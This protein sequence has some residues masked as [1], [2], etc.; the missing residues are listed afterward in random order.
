M[1]MTKLDKNRKQ[2]W[3]Q[4]LKGLKRGATLTWRELD[5]W[6]DGDAA[7]FSKDVK[8]LMKALDRHE[9]GVLRGASQEAE[10]DAPYVFHHGLRGD[11]AQ[12]YEQELEQLPR[13]SRVGEFRMARRYE[14][15]RARMAQAFTAIGFADE[16][17]R[18]ILLHGLEGIE[19]PSKAKRA[20]KKRE[21]ALARLSEVEDLRNAFFEGS[22]YLVM[23]GV[24]KYRK[25]GIDTLDLVQ[26]GNVS[27]FQAAEGFDWRR[28]VRF[29]TYAEYWINQAFLK[30]LYNN[31]RTVR[32]PVWVQKALKKIKD[33]QAQAV[34]KTGRELSASEVG[35]QLDMPASKVESLLRTQRYSVSL[36]AEIG[37]E[38]GAATMS[39][40]LVDKETRPVH[41]QVVDVALPDRLAEILDALP[42]RERTILQL[43]FGL[44]GKPP[45]TLSMVGEVLGVSAERVRQLQETALRRLKLPKTR[46]RLAQFVGA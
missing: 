29:K 14:F 33:L 7:S 22:L 38:E 39:E 19:W 17:V 41:E 18:E 1:K 5:P 30:M 43:R 2:T 24:H 20:P 12:R 44:G 6:I 11:G 37:G 23:K 27:L 4:F 10:Y 16:Q 9:V 32:V 8:R 35:K 36:D 40:M 3:S 21:F 28:D 46:E 45:M 13:L 25:L 31:T 42:E 15:L 26:E 34:H